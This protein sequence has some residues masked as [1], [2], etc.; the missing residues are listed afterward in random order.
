[1]TGQILIAIFIA[2]HFDYYC[3]PKN[4]L[5]PLSDA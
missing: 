2:D 1:M 3:E 5:L 4:Y